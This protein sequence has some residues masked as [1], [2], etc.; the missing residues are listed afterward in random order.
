M[1][2]KL[3]ELI[4]SYED[5]NT[6]GEFR[7]WLNKLELVAKLQKV[8]NLKSFVPLFLNG[9]AFSLYEQLPTSTKDDYALLIKEL[10][11]AYSINCYSPYEQLRERVL[12][13]S[14]TVDVYLADVR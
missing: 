4:K 7:T 13:E 9:P 6:S 2:V 3:S 12:Q 1:A 14:E 11:T 5:S 8:T 10:L